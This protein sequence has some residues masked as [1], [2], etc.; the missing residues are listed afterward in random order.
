MSSKLL[1]GLKEYFGYDSLRPAQVPIIDSVLAGRDTLAIMPTGGGKSLCYQLPA[2]INEGLVLVV[3][4]LIALMHDQV[5]SLKKNGINAGIL[6]SSI[7]PYDQEIVQNQAQDGTLKLLY[8]SPER[9]FAR[10]SAFID[11]MG[12]LNIS[13]IAIDEAHCVSQWGHDFRPEYSRLRIIKETFPQIP[14]TALTATADELTRGDIVKQLELDNPNIFISSFDRPNIT[15]TVQPK[16][17]DDQA[18]K[19]LTN[20]IKSFNGE[21]GIVYCL[22][23][24]STE[25]VSKSLTKLGIKSAPFHAGL[26]LEEKEETYDKF[27]QDKLQVVCA[28]IAFGMGVDKP[29]VRFV[30]H[31]N[32]PKSIEGYYQETGRAGRDGLA[33]EALLLYSPGDAGVYR[34]F[35]DMAK[36]AG[37]P[38]TFKIFQ[39]LQYDKLD[40]LVDF[41][42][43]GHCRRRILLQYFNQRLEKD[44]GNCDGCLSPV[45][46]MDG[47][48][49]SQKIISAIYRTEQKFG[50]GYIVD[51]LLGVTND[52]MENYGHSKLPTFGICK[53]NSKEELMFYTNQLISLGYLQVDYE[54][55]IKTLSLNDQS[56]SIAAGK[57]KVELIPYE[58][59]IKPIL[60]SKA[61]KKSLAKLDSQ[62]QEYFEILRKV[63][64]QIAAKDNVPAFVVFGNATL[65]D[66]VDKRPKTKQEFSQISGVGTHKLEKYW[67]EFRHSLLA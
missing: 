44:C 59:K 39:K 62:D 8:V 16:L 67:P 32:M 15:Y 17:A 12:K 51:L 11:W 27:M 28:T 49:I 26:S 57:I 30:A 9:L 20:F 2:V 10:E 7:S 56:M 61:S 38:E 5:Q 52:R 18:T 1:S 4:P 25:E 66:I 42:S 33:S 50:I 19:Q 55:F 14:V 58:E 40:R 3:S 48:E 21:S 23:R 31:W 22:S 65:L 37:D 60:K 54:G 45:K 6:N 47:L 29:D 41:C 63:R 46:K 64:Q 36:P 24:K 35:I 13:L 53:T 43:T 34:R